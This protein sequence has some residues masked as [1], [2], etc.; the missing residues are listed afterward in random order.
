MIKNK[1]KY[2]QVLPL[3]NPFYI[4][5]LKVKGR[6]KIYNVYINQKKTGVST[7]ISDEADFRTRKITRGK[8]NIT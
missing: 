2:I 5:G 4:G 8:Q 3:R 1:P 7:L 6:T